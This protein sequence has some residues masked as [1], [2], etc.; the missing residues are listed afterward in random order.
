MAQILSSLQIIL[1]DSASLLKKKFSIFSI[2]TPFPTMHKEI[3]C[4]TKDK[5]VSWD[6]SESKGST[7]SEQNPSPHH[8]QAFASLARILCYSQLKLVPAGPADI[9]SFY[10]P[11]QQCPLLRCF[12]VIVAN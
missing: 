12:S 3:W 2:S 1:L 4:F 9:K 11:L 7:T 8:N 6:W 5:P 10:I